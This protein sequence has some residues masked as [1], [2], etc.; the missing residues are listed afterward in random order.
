MPHRGDHR[1]SGDGWWR[2]LST[3]AWLRGEKWKD[4]FTRV[5]S[6]YLVYGGCPPDNCEKKYLVCPYK[7]FYL[8]EGGIGLG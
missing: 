7:S 3:G 5:V 4:P 8:N 1:S 2:R 6:D